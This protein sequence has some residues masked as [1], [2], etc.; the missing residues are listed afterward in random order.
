MET[1]DNEVYKAEVIEYVDKCF[2]TTII[3][4]LSAVEEEFDKDEFVLIRKKI[5]DLCNDNKRRAVRLLQKSGIFKSQYSYL[6][7]KE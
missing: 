7:S 3:G 5:L 2:T 1:K 4:A 6:F